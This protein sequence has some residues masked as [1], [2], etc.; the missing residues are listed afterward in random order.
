MPDED[1]ST[2]ALRVINIRDLY[3][4][5]MSRLAASSPVSHLRVVTC[6]SHTVEDKVE[7]AMLVIYAIIQSLK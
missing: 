7:C 6:K 2:Q 5:C 1:L 4:P 3:A